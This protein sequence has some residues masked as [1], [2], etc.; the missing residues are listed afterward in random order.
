MSWSRSKLSNP[1]DAV[2]VVVVVVV[3]VVIGGGGGVDEGPS[4]TGLLAAE[5][6]RATRFIGIANW[7]RSK[8]NL[9]RKKDWLKFSYY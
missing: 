2:F 8:S 3:V 1:V 7:W 6:A 9:K 5:N 4:R